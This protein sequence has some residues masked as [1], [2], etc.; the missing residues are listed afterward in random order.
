MKSQRG[1]TLIE[2]LVVIAVIALL[3]GLLLPALGAARNSARSTACSVNARSIAQGVSFYNGDTEYFPPSYVYADS[4]TGMTWVKEQQLDSNPNPANGYIH[5]SAA[6]LGDGDKVPEKAFECPSAP[7]G[8][9]PATNPGQSPDDWES[10]Q[11]NDLG[12]GPPGGPTPDDRQARRMAYTG[13]AAIF[14]RNK[15]NITAARRNQLVRDSRIT[16]PV[17]T[18]L[19]TEFLQLNGDWRTIADGNESKSHRPITPFVGGS[20]GTN[21]YQEPD[22]GSVARFFYPNLNELYPKDQLGPYMIRD[23]NTV[24][25]AVGR[26]H[27]SKDRR[28]GGS[29]NFS[30]VDGHVENMSV[31]ESIE[32]RLWGDRFYSLTGRNTLVDDDGF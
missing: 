3:V 32:R 13:N 14:P 28:I 2:L 12:Q 23:G 17:R 9:A 25:N 16:F 19:A 20:S 5:W 21:V 22:L 15:F 30:F 7:R 8:G 1:F 6:L 29:A 27:P 31:A 11:Q 10:W 18:I 26:T 24:L 4:Q